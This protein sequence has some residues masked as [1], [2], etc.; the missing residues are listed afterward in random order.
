LPFRR[1]FSRWRVAFKTRERLGVVVLAVEYETYQKF[2][3]CLAFQVDS[4]ACRMRHP[5][6]FISLLSFMLLFRI[7]ANSHEQPLND[8]P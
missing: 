6:P 5:N 7:R 3:P 2:P 8:L 4:L 1:P